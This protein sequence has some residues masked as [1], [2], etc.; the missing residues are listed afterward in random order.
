MAEP[1]PDK[2]PVTIDQPIQPQDGQ[3]FLWPFHDLANESDQSEDSD[4]PRVEHI[5]DAA[6]PRQFQC[7]L[8]ET[9]L[10]GTAW[11]QEDSPWA[12]SRPTQYLCDKCFEPEKGI[13]GFQKAMFHACGECRA[14]PRGSMLLAKCGECISLAIPSC[15]LRAS[16][17]F[18]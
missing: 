6:E 1:Q 18:P 10:R 12:A 8:C 17:G 13:G 15:V 11:R 4:K 14:P 2:Q 3:T 5:E 7:Q 16:P 9:V